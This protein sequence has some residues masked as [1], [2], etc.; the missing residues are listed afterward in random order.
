[1]REEQFMIDNVPF[2][3]VQFNLGF[4]NFRSMSDPMIR[5][6]K[7][8][9]KGDNSKVNKAPALHIQLAKYC[10]VYQLNKQV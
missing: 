1:M 7:T 5:N 2:S 9:S 3:C 8:Q 4:E 10:N 6:T